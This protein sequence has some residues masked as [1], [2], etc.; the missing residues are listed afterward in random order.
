MAQCDFSLFNEQQMAKW[1]PIHRRPREQPACISPE[2]EARI[3]D[4]LSRRLEGGRHLWGIAWRVF[5]FLLGLY[6]V[7]TLVGVWTM[8]DQLKY[9]KSKNDELIKEQLD[10]WKKEIH[11]RISREFEK[12]PFRTTMQSVA[13]SESKK[14]LESQVQPAILAFS[15]NVE[16]MRLEIRAKATAATQDTKREMTNFTDDLAQS[17]AELKAEYERVA[18]ELST[19]QFRNELTALADDA[20]AAGNR[21]SLKALTARQALA[22]LGNNTVSISVAAEI[23]RVKTAYIDTSRVRKTQVSYGGKKPEDAGTNEMIVALLSNHDWTVR[24]KTAEYLKNRK[25]LGVVEAMFGCAAGDNNL[26]VVAE[27]VRE[28]ESLTGETSGDVFGYEDLLRWWQDNG[29]GFN[30][31]LQY[32]SKK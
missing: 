4:Q 31:E 8:S 3:V 15:E 22:P 11:Y 20:I 7:L 10:A 16:E 30:F 24:A 29:S 28:L 17:R 32:G 1:I 26:N 2:M 6:G 9:L 25:A 23:L 5:L 18:T 13:G 27:C 12:D 19:L 21:D 14:L